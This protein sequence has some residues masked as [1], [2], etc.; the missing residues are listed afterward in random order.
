MLGLILTMFGVGGIEQSIT[1]TEL[2]SSLAVSVLGLALMAV[3]VL[4]L[5]RLDI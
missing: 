1:N 3:G 2:L 5:K 4:A